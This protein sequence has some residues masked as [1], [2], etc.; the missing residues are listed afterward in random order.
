MFSFIF[1]GLLVFSLLINIKIHEIFLIQLYKNKDKGWWTLSIRIGYNRI[2]AE[3]RGRKEASLWEE[4]AAFSV[5]FL[6][7][8]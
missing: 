8:L 3:S 5:Q 4:R 7:A 6:A 1:L 2:G